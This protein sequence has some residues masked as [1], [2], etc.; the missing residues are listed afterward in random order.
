[1]CMSNIKW[2]ILS[3]EEYEEKIK[4]LTAHSINLKRLGFVFTSDSSTVPAVK[5]SASL[6][7][8]LISAGTI[9]NVSRIITYTVGGY[10]FAELLVRWPSIKKSLN[11]LFDGWR[12]KGWL[13]TLCTTKKI[14]FASHEKS[15]DV[16]VINGV[17]TDKLKM[18]LVTTSMMH[19]PHDIV[20]VKEEKSDQY[21]NKKEDI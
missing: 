11:L 20:I 18:A 16:V 13:E 8:K 7:Q 10:F 12:D 21:G 2:D 17:N 19:P 14:A 3:K 4:K 1:M 15:G 5:V 6:F 9:D